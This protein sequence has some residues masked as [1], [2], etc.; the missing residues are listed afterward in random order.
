MK[1]NYSACERFRPNRVYYQLD[2]ANS[3]PLIS[4]NEFSLRILKFHP[5]HS[6]FDKKKWINENVKNNR[7]FKNWVDDSNSKRCKNHKSLKILS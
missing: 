3:R 2:F 4:T 7:K 6:D 1:I 5:I